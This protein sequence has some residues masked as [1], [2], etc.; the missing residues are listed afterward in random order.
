MIT[1]KHERGLFT[2]IRNDPDN[3]MNNRNT[4]IRKQK[5][6]KKQLFGRFKR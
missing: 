5:W 6:E 2:A 3:T 1:G 4:T